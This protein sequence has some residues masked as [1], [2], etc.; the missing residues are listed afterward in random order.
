[1]AICLRMPPR[2]ELEDY[3]RGHYS[4]ETGDHS[5]RARAI[6]EIIDIPSDSRTECLK[7]LNKMG[8]NR[9]TLFPDLDGAAQY[10]N[11]LWGLDFDTSLGQIRSI[12][13]TP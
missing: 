8:M 13:E 6:L 12:R 3:I 1:M 9:L 10:I 2:S 4:Q 7:F 5:I 11:T